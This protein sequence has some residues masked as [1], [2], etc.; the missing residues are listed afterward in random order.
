MYRCFLNR[1]KGGGMS[2]LK[3]VRLEGEFGPFLAF[4][5]AFGFIP[6]LLRAQTLLPRVI[7]AQAM[8]EGAVRLREGAIPRGQKERILLSIAADR[9]DGYCAGVDSKVL[10]SL[11]VSD[12]EVDDLLSDYRN[13]GLS[14]SDSA[15]LQFCLKLSRHAP[16]VSSED[17]EA[18]RTCG[19]E[20]EAILETVVLT[21]LAVYRCTLSAGLG[22]KPDFEPRR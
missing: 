1:A 19:F 12:S 14:S 21:A 2:F 4:Q 22:P 16:S 5:V 10:S 18:L 11:G 17:I 13:A 6:N 7:E 8:L 3:E 15:S 9:Q 20:D